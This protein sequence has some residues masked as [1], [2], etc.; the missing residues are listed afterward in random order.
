MV[1]VTLAFGAYYIV[2][3]Y[4]SWLKFN[5]LRVLSMVNYVRSLVN[6]GKQSEFTYFMQMLFH[7]CLSK[8]CSDMSSTDSKVQIHARPIAMAPKLT[9]LSDQLFG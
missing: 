6:R 7:S 2:K 8:L 3:A 5:L 1:L 4:L 9:T